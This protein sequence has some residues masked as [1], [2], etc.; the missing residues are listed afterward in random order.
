M[1]I[2]NKILLSA[3]LVMGLSS[4]SAKS[5]ESGWSLS[6]I[7]KGIGSLVIAGAVSYAGFR[8]WRNVQTNAL[9]QAV[10]NNDDAGVKRAI[11]LG[12]DVNAQDSRGEKALFMAVVLVCNK[13][14][15]STD[16]IELLLN[17]GADIETSNEWGASVLQVAIEFQNFP[18]ME[19]LLKAGADVK[20]KNA[21]RVSWFFTAVVKNNIPIVEILLKYGASLDERD[22]SGNTV[23]HIAARKNYKEMVAVLLAAGRSTH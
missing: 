16:M 22:A 4:G 13:H 18:L 15:N 1:E 9:V 23:L 20:R 3:L 10:E 6:T 14:V 12:A 17:H 11:N 2:K 19:L 7:G 8:A 21:D 5:A